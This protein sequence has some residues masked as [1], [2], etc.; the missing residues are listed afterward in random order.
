MIQGFINHT[1]RDHKPRSDVDRARLGKVRKLADVICERLN[2]VRPLTLPLQYHSEVV[3]RARALSSDIEETLDEFF[4]TTDSKRLLLLAARLS[5]LFEQE[6]VLL[7][8]LSHSNGFVLLTGE[9]STVCEIDGLRVVESTEYS[10]NIP[11]EA[12]SFVIPDPSV[13]PELALLRSDVGEVYLLD[14]SKAQD[15]ILKPSFDDIPLGRLLEIRDKIFHARSDA[16]ALEKI[17]TFKEREF[18]AAVTFF[19]L[20]KAA[21]PY[22]SCDR[23]QILGEIDRI[24]LHNLVVKQLHVLLEKIRFSGIPDLK[25]YLFGES[26]RGNRERTSLLAS[27]G[28]SAFTWSILFEHAVV[29][30]N[31]GFASGSTSPPQIAA[32]QRIFRGLYDRFEY[33]Q[34]LVSADPESIRSWSRERLRTF[35]RDDLQHD[36]D[37]ASLGTER[38][39][40]QVMRT[41]RP[42]QPST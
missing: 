31:P 36:F 3:E 24:Y 1:R 20:R 26:Y 30:F 2:T 8:V 42:S 10:K 15:S 5:N 28:Y 11:S 4:K 16:A 39:A 29:Y 25:D 38:A 13:I 17:S 41:L 12:V 34:H 7:K 9:I 27:L 18:K 14:V 40:A 23:P 22:M 37:P 33:L 19:L 6:G 32:M 21:E 35:Y